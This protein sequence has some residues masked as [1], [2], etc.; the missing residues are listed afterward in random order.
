MSKKND[1][2]ER[3][4]FFRGTVLALVLALLVGGGTWWFFAYT[5]DDGLI[6]PN[7]SAFGVDLGGKTPEE[8]AALLH[9]HTDNTYSAQNLMV[10]LSST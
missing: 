1:R 4:T 6:Y 5:K 10:N 9:Q 3:R 7:V 8:A 2:E